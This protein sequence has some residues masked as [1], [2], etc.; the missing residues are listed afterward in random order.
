MDA[1][2][3]GIFSMIPVH[4][5]IE[6]LK[7]YC[8]TKLGIHLFYATMESIDQTYL[9]LRRNHK[10]KFTMSRYKPILEYV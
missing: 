2:L 6:I 4:F 5:R 7:G 9:K 1:A 3:I 8:S 10:K